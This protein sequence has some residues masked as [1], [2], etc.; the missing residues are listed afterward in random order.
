MPTNG[1]AQK[2]ASNSDEINFKSQGYLQLAVC[3][4]PHTTTQE[5]LSADGLHTVT[6]EVEDASTTLC[7]SSYLF[8]FVYGQFS[9]Q[10]RARDGM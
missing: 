9:H 8:Q 3:K 5:W 4:A 6:D 10:V 1:N 2:A 7:H